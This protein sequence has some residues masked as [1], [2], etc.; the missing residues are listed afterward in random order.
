M[1]QFLSQIYQIKS[2]NRKALA[3]LIDPDQGSKSVVNIAQT[4][5][6]HKVDFVFV[7]G[8]LVTSG[9]LIETIKNI[10]EFYTGYIYLFPGNEFMIDESADGILFL[11][12][13]SGRNPE[14]LIGKQVVAAP[15][16][17]KSGLD[18]IPTAYLLIDGGKESSVSYI[19]NTKPIPSD[20]IDIAVATAQAGKLM[21][22]QCI[23]MD[24]GS[25]AL[26]HIP[27]KMV[28]G[29]KEN[30]KLPLII[31]GGIRNAESAF[32][33]YKSGA[34]ILVIGNGVEQNDNLIQT[35]S[36]VKTT[37]SSII[38]I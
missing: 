4:C 8:S 33:L 32:E 26:Y 12:L 11:S 30:V 19:S 14:Y 5:E 36:E 31:G 7:G 37:I 3:V 25:G 6:E 15:T 35:I 20:K 38:D 9:V 13:L 24:S 18:V 10:R 16:L 21:G 17:I 1:S 29:V 27:S 2:E 28:V 23:Y 34:D 22:M